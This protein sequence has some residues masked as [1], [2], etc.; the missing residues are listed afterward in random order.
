MPKFFLVLVCYIYLCPT[1]YLFAQETAQTYGPITP[2]ER[3]WNI[4][5][6]VSPP[7]I[8]RHQAILALH[9]ANPQ[10]FGVSCNMN[11]LKIGETLRIPSLSEMQALS[12]DDAI[13]E[14]NRQIQQWES[15]RQNP[16]VCPEIEE[17]VEETNTETRQTH[18]LSST[19]PTETTST[20][21]ALAAT[22]NSS[23]VAEQNDESLSGSIFLFTLIATI[24]IFAFLMTFF[25]LRKRKLKKKA[26]ENQ[27]ADNDS[28][29]E[30]INEMPL[31][32]TSDEKQL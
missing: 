14:F 2:G 22:A 5:A 12:P 9:K 4:A 32:K 7:S 21:S 28:D 17:Q 18:P 6:K 11:S 16:I 27:I 1:S 26:Q 24:V 29:F 23:A 30:P 15:R 13:K 8:T 19:Q 31:P 25:L 3:L 10:A 20:V